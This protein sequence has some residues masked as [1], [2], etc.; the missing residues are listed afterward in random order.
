MLAPLPVIPTLTQGPAGDGAQEGGAA[1]DGMHVHEMNHQLHQPPVEEEAAQPPDK[2]GKA[3][4]QR[5]L[6]PRLHLK[7]KQ[8]KSFDSTSIVKTFQSPLD[9]IFINLWYC[10]TS[11]Q[12]V[13]L[14]GTLNVLGLKEKKIMSDKYHMIPLIR[15]IKKKKNQYE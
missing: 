2:D 11:R 14:V 8:K 1:A 4:L 5:A 10:R 3:G 12:R 15:G 6:L 9:S 7:W 13:G